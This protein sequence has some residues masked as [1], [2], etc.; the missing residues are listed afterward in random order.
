MILT[1]DSIIGYKQVSLVPKSE[2]AS[3][4]STIHTL[5]P[6]EHTQFIM[7]MKQDRVSKEKAARRRQISQLEH[8]Q[9]KA[10]LEK[11]QLELEKEQRL[12]EKKA[13]IKEHLK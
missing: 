9:H 2:T 12:K 3:R 11:E 8:S 4:H 6:K 10:Q 1:Q 7:K 5:S 13:K